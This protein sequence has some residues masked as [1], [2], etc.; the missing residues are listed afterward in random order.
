MDNLTDED[1]LRLVTEWQKSGLD[2]STWCAAR[3][4][5]PRTLRSWQE[6]LCRE[7]QPAAESPVPGEHLST[8]LQAFEERLGA[9]ERAVD[10]VRTAVAECQGAA[11][12][13]AAC[14]SASSVM[15]VAAEPHQDEHEAAGGMP[16]MESVEVPAVVPTG[17]EHH[18][19][20]AAEP[21]VH[22]PDD[23][24]ARPAT[25]PRRRRSFF[26]FFDALAPVT[27]AETA[28]ALDEVAGVQQAV[29]AQ[30]VAAAG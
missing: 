28:N 11:D 22:E 21:V 14:R 16:T 24:H 19:Q 5:K 7:R 12:S 23:E 20:V 30:R 8:A 29:A 1:R 4:L 13:A 18:E 26:D 10:E 17:V 27:D 15:G 6:K 3:G 25:P 9:L 2:Q